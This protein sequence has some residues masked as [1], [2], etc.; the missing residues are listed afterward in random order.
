MTSSWETYWVGLGF[1]FNHFEKVITTPALW[2][3]PFFENIIS[4]DWVICLY[5]DIKMS[6]E[7]CV[8]TQ[9]LDKKSN[10]LLFENPLWSLPLS[11]LIGAEMLFVYPTLIGVSQKLNCLHKKM[12]DLE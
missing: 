6:F 5:M 3:T 2:N 8:V 10:F 12:C 9:N 1:Q 7:M 11:H 4:S